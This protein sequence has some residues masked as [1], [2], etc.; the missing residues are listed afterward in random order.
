[1]AARI[2]PECGT[3]FAPSGYEFVANSVRFLCPHCNQAYYGTSPL[4]HLVPDRFD[5]VR[6]SRNISMDEM[7]LLPTEGVREEQTTSIANPWTEPRSPGIRP[8]AVA[9]VRTI[10]LGL[11]RPADLIRG[12]PPAS[13]AGRAVLFSALTN[14]TYVLI[15]ASPI[16]LMVGFVAPGGLGAGVATP[17]A[18]LAM[19]TSI[20]MWLG[21]AV[22]FSL[23]PVLVWS[24]CIHGMLMLTGPVEFPLRRTLQSV[25][26]SSGANVLMA[27]P[28][29]GLYLV[30]WAGWAWWIAVAAIMVCVG[31]RV[32][33]W[34]AALAVIAPP[35]ALLLLGIGAVVVASYL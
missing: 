19:L 9:W 31:M 29:F 14:L 17:R 4:G 18:A 8:F 34:R 2:C 21:G 23:V 1:M 25:C 22:L 15:S 35:I 13:S 11:T 33:G 12:T 30:G 20:G 24:L 27:I 10:G 6:C 26:Y 32:A 28:C 16:V 7:K 3:P 5:C